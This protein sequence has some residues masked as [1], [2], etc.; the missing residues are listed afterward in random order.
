MISNR[1]KF[2]YD[3]FRTHPNSVMISSSALNWV[4]T[5]SVLILI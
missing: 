5:T 3:H 1:I 2:G 4:M